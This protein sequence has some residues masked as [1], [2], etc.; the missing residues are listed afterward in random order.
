[1]NLQCSTELALSY[2]SP[3]QMARVI[4][5]DWCARE[6]Y[7]PACASDSLLRSPV[8]TPAIDFECPQCAQFFQ[9][10]GLR[11]W[12][13]RRIVDG[14]YDAMIR[15]IRAD[16][17]PNLLILQYSS[18]WLVRNL[19]LVPRFFF[20]ESI[21]EKRKPLG[22]LARRAGWIGCNILLSEIPSDGR[23]DIVRQ[24][25][26]LPSEQVRREF[27]RIRGL[28][29]VP[30]SIR[31]WTLDVFNA[32]RCIGKRDF[33]LKDIYH[34]EDSLQGRHPSNRNIRPKIRQQL[35]VLRDMGVLRFVGRGKYSLGV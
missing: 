29:D 12:N 35:Q 8:N 14:A 24:G 13:Q 7:C 33:S 1:M 15:S 18:E 27:D 22:A 30:P 3:S 20:S 21:I 32:I 31:G 34:L 6:V 4:T 19:L 2:K 11:T 26:V 17:V 16:K 5:E 9:L 25:Q 23:I 28:E 10:K